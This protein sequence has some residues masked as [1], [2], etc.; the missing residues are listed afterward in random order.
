MTIELFMFLFTV[1][2]TVSSLITQAAKKQLKYLSCNMIALW[3]SMIVG[4]G[5]TICAYILLDI[6][7]TAKNDVCIGLMTVCIWVGSMVGYD[8]VVQTISQIKG[9]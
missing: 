9:A 3:S 6:P 8:K 2:S 4:I 5:G 1:G 7:Y